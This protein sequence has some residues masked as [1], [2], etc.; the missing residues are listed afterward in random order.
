MPALALPSKD[1]LFKLGEKREPL[2]PGNCLAGFSKCPQAALGIGWPRM[3]QEP[4][5]ATCRQLGGK[6]EPRA[7]SLGSPDPAFA[8]KRT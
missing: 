6:R 8:A 2:L 5:G 4:V 3:L 1:L 7:G